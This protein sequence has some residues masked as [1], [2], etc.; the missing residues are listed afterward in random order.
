MS[1]SPEDQDLF[2]EGDAVEDWWEDP[3]LS[4]VAFREFFLANRRRL[5]HVVG[6]IAALIRSEQEQQLGHDGF[7]PERTRPETFDLPLLQLLTIHDPVIL[8]F[9]RAEVAERL[10]ESS[11]KDSPPPELLIFAA[12]LLRTRAPNRRAKGGDRIARDVLIA[13]AMSLV[14]VDARLIVLGGISEEAADYGIP[15]THLDED[16]LVKRL[17]QQSLSW[18]ANRLACLIGEHPLLEPFPDALLS[19]DA[20]RAVWRKR[21]RLLKWV[22]ISSP[23]VDEVLPLSFWVASAE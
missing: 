7:L 18:T 8:D 21:E 12:R 15:F 19:S 1:Q 10:E 22:A 20:I 5:A 3:E 17:P 13:A 2:L 4:R 23:K 6:L 14:A 9:A 11:Q 16:W